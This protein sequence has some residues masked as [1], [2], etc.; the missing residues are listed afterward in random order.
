MYDEK[1]DQ[2]AIVNILNLTANFYFPKD[3]HA[4]SI[5]DAAR[6]VE[7]CSTEE[8]AVHDDPLEQIYVHCSALYHLL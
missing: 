7:D 4:I 3:K 2:L 6:S 8:T 5:Q 1:K